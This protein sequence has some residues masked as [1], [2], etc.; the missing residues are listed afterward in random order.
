[1]TEILERDFGAFFEVPFGV[2]EPGSPYVSPMK[3]DLRRFLSSKENPLFDSEDDFTFFAARRDDRPVGRIVVH[4]HR[5]SN[6]LHLTN[7]ASFGFFDCADDRE[8]AGCLLDAATTWARS[9]GFA[10]LVGNFNLTAMQQ[11]GVQTGGFEHTAYTDMI[12]NPP[13]IPELLD[14]HGFEAF[15]PMRTFEL[16]LTTAA[17]PAVHNPANEGET[18]A[19]VRRRDFGQRMEEARRVLNDGFA[20][21][22]MFVPL[23]AEEFKFQAGEMM[24]IIDPRLSSVLKKDGQPVGVVICIPDLTGFMRA[25]RSRLNITT[26]WHYLRHRFD[27]KRAVIIFYSVSRDQHGQGIMGRMLGRTLQALREGGYDKLGITWIAD[28]NPASLRQMEKLG[29]KPLHTLHLFRKPLA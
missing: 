23:S 13:H 20:A 6:R 12:V 22:P 3:A 26:P 8:V 16:D 15:F 11:C 28:E 21:N 29:A 1:M 17:M 24:A 27:R 7:R 19:P 4:H 2:Y 25:T 9:R 18:Y 5:A 10:E 14:T